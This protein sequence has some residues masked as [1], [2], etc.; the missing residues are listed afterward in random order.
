VNTLRF[1]REQE[2]GDR[3]FSM[4]SIGCTASRKSLPWWVPDPAS[5][6][7]WQQRSMDGTSVDGVARE[8]APWWG[9]FLYFATYSQGR[10]TPQPT[11]TRPAVCKPRGVGGTSG[12]HR[13]STRCGRFTAAAPGP[14]VVRALAPVLWCPAWPQE[15][16]GAGHHSHRGR[17]GPRA[18]EVAPQQ[19]FPRLAPPSTAPPLQKSRPCYFKRQHHPT[20]V[21]PC[22]CTSEAAWTRC[23]CSQLGALIPARA[24]LALRRRSVSV[25]TGCALPPPGPR[26]ELR[27]PIGARERSRFKWPCIWREQTSTIQMCCTYH[28]YR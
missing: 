16:I 24:A 9:A 4:H 17:A 6:I 19:R 11:I 1:L 25:E 27:L 14:R 2:A 10:A 3:L 21:H 15:L 20:A 18:C 8:V 26:P 28:R 13:L 7:P 5:A 12:N 22:T 23:D